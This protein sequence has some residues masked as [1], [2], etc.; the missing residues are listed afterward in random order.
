MTWDCATWARIVEL[1]TL[2]IDLWER[3]LIKEAIAR[4]HEQRSGGSQTVGHRPRDTLSQDR[5][6]GVER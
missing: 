4:T 6:Y 5:E 3:R 2:R 1:D